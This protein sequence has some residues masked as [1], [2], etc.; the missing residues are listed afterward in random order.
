VSPAAD[1]FIPRWLTVCP[2]S[3]T[4]ANQLNVVYSTN[5]QLWHCCASDDCTQVT[6]ETFE[7]PAPTNLTIIW[8][9]SAS[10]VTKFLVSSATQ[11]S[12]T[13]GA[14]TS[15]TFTSS[16]IPANPPG[17]SLTKPASSSA[18]STSNSQTP[19]QVR[20]GLSIDGIVGLAVAI[21]GTIA[22]I[23]GTYFAW[24]TYKNKKQHQKLHRTPPVPL[25]RRPP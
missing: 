1:S 15:S 12:S 24:K 18:T 11:T 22:T 21:P 17:T 5:D 20:R 19:G 10:T 23:I 6:G 7:A 9:P 8:P 3:R 2:E 14:T 4:D 16:S 13:E 25:A